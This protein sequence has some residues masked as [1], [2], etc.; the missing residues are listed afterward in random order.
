MED[1]QKQLV[2]KLKTANNI[3]VTVSRD[4]SVD[5]LAAL[6][7]LTLLLTKQEKHAAAVFSGSVPSTIEF[8]QPEETIEKDTNS[9]RDFI[10]ALDKNKADKLRY[11]VEDNLVRIFITPYKTS[12]TQDDF[13]FTQGDLNVDLII[14]LGVKKQEDLDEAI[15][16]HG[17]ILHDATIA[18]INVDAEGGLGT[19]NW[20]QPDA[21]SLSELV[22]RLGQA[23]DDKLF[24]AQISTAL[25]TGIV[26]ETDRFSNEK[27]TPQTMSA[28]A[29]LMTGG[30]NQQLVASKLMD[31][32]QLATLNLR[33]ETPETPPLETNA[34]EIEHN[35]DTPPEPAS[36][37]PVEIVADAPAE[38]AVETPQEPAAEPQEPQVPSPVPDVPPAPDLPV[39][40]LP[41]PDVE[42]LPSETGS[43]PAPNEP[44]AVPPASAP[45][46]E[47]V[48]PPEPI[49][50]TPPS[51][52]VPEPVPTPT[53][54]PGPGSTTTAPTLPEGMALGPDPTQSTEEVHTHETLTE[55]EEA[56]ASP[57]LKDDPT[58]NTARDEVNKAI[59]E[60]NVEPTA[61]ENPEQPQPGGAV[62][63][64][65]ELN[66]SDLPSD[67]TVPT[68]SPPT[69]SDSVDSDTAT[70]AEDNQSDDQS[71][72]DP[73]SP[74]PVPPPIPF[75][76]GNPS[77]PQ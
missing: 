74:P 51:P 69:S 23:I 6:I 50:V 15:M 25:M 52:P 8:L 39:F 14:A 16:A 38:P 10:I 33:Q 49:D 70:P 2:D 35:A 13:E 21:S 18:S 62:Q 66:P 12:I 59:N 60:T 68:P 17:Q 40:E 64:G 58:L 30:A 9:L 73:N 37:A 22:T 45:E 1:A 77:P 67:P 55:L 34:V 72:N 42:S 11:K 57:H 26:A 61:A 47:V 5:Q 4:P 63:F 36:E 75:Q 7:G 19:I 41:T 48:A 3:L 46:P 54:Q 56:V 24:D 32:G 65:K 71:K 44:P 53:T 31:A 29:I 20:H 27:T 43:A 76:F 28:S